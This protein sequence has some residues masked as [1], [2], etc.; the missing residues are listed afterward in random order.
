MN[1]M[2]IRNLQYIFA[3]YNAA[4]RDLHLHVFISYRN[5]DSDLKKMAGV[6]NLFD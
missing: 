4:Q 3:Y 6:L 1:E 2:R 5:A